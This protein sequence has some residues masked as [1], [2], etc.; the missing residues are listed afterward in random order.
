M[1]PYPSPSARK[2]DGLFGPRGAGLLTINPVGF[3]DLT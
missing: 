3:L 1:R 2:T